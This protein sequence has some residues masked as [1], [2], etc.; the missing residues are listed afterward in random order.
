MQMYAGVSF[1]ILIIPEISSENI[2]M[3]VEIILN[4]SIL[5]HF[6]KFLLNWL[7]HD[8]SH[9]AEIVGY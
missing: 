6:Q 2:K 8:V 5:V 4:V 9:V 7:R 3:Q 1:N